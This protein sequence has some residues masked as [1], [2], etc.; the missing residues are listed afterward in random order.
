VH[1][2]LFASVRTPQEIAAV[3]NQGFDDDDIEEC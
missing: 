1:Q 2:L 3:L